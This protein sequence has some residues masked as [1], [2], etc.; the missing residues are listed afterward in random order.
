MR[1]TQDLKSVVSYSRLGGLTTLLMTYG[2]GLCR[3][4]NQPHKTIAPIAYEN[5]STNQPM[6]PSTMLQVNQTHTVEDARTGLAVRIGNSHAM[7]WLH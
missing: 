2:A 6:K 3:K 7:Y 1:W 5:Q 4:G